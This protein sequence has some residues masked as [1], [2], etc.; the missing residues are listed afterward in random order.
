MREAYQ[1][2][3]R[4]PTGNSTQIANVRIYTS[5]LHWPKTLDVGEDGTI[6]VTNGGDQGETCDLTRPF[7]GGILALDSQGTD[8]LRTVAKGLRNPIYLR[9]HH[10][11]HNHCFA[12]ELARDYSA[13]IQGR[14][15]L[16]PVEDGD[17]WGFPCCASKDLPYTDVCL[18]CG[19]DTQTSGASEA[20][21]I[22]AQQCSPRC[23]DTTAESASFIIGDTPFGLDFID[24]QFPAPWDHRVIV[25][26]HGAAGSWAGARVVAIAY[27]PLTGQ[28]FPGT[29]LPGQDA[30]SM[31]DF[32]QGW[33]D[34]NTDHGRPSDVTVSPDGRLF[35]ANDNT[36]AI[37]WIAPVGP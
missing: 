14:E 10:D 5:G 22:A 13:D 23:T 24:S 35:V 1:T 26:T 4:S 25:A 27:D 33:D 7:H 2:G 20:M 36:G 9:C 29:N 3:D 21:C 28:P 18:S 15:K 17:D 32:L 30:G 11:G 8:G 12:N 31:Q 16:I 34:G 19:P 37:V 6:F